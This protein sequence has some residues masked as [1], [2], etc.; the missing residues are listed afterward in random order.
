[1]KTI[2]IFLLTVNT[3]FTIDSKLELHRINL[4]DK[5]NDCFSAIDEVRNKVAVFDEKTNKWLL[6]DGRQFVGG[7]CE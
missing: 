5:I 3:N 7:M 4:T 2:I 1:M 6:K